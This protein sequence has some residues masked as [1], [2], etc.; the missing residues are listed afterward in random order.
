MLQ[1]TVAIWSTCVAIT[2]CGSL[3][4]YW[5]HTNGTA[6]QQP[7]SNLFWLLL[8]SKNTHK[9]SDKFVF[10]K[11][12]RPIHHSGAKS[13]Y[14]TKWFL[15]FGIGQY[16]APLYL[17]RGLWTTILP[18]GL[19]ERFNFLFLWALLRGLMPYSLQVCL[20]ILDSCLGSCDCCPV[21]RL[22]VQKLLYIVM[23]RITPQL[24]QMV[25]DCLDSR[26]QCGYG[27][28]GWYLYAVQVHTTG[29][30]NIPL[31]S[32]MGSVYWFIGLILAGF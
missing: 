3:G 19:H 27:V 21:G 16:G 14:T 26:S 13:S 2:R 11:F 31:L 1:C 17:W 15:V 10:Q 7:R 5:T 24:L 9:K 29:W 30:R 28:S 18:L 12:P 23:E 25:S 4:L 32:Y 22:V 20:C 6:V 8:S